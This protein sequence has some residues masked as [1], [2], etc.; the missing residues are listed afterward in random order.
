M[1]ELQAELE[2]W[3]LEAGR[4]EATLEDALRA[5]GAAT[6]AGGRLLRRDRRVGQSARRLDGTRGLAA[7]EDGAA[8]PDRRNGA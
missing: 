1:A 8:D 5:F 4:L 2:A 6:G 7:P 3:L